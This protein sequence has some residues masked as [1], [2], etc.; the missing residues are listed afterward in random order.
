M[1]KN[2]VCGMYVIT[3][4][5]TGK[6]YVGSSSDIFARISHHKWALK[7]NQNA[8][9]KLQETFN[10]YPDLDQLDILI[11]PCKGREEAYDKEQAMLDRHWGKDICLNTCRD[12]RNPISEQLHCKEVIERRSVTMK[13][14]GATEEFK[15]AMAK[16]SDKRWSQEGARDAFKGAGNPFAKKVSVDGVVYGSVKEAV[17]AI[18][19][20]EKTI[21]KRANLETFVNY[22]WV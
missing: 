2:K 7:N 20:S 22:Q 5:P 16:H 21:R 4:L 10:T 1:R 6:L 8:S 18:N 15:A 17:L 19:V 3:H 11:H 14:K 12:V 9:V 13:A